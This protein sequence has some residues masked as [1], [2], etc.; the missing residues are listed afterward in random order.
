MA[1]ANSSAN[2][3]TFGA[4]KGGKARKGPKKRCRKERN[5]RGQ[6]RL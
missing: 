2:K 5:Y 4:R 3:V 6:G 1:K